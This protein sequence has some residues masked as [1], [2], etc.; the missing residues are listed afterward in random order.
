MHLHITQNQ[1]RS[2]ILHTINLDFSNM[3]LYTN[4][5]EHRYE[6]NTLEP[7]IAI[8]INY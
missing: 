8:D 3:N 6:A 1:L 5:A 4:V 7:Q 2:Q